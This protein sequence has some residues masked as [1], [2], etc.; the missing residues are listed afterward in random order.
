MVDYVK[1]MLT[2]R[3]QCPHFHLDV[4][5]KLGTKVFF[6]HVNN[7]ILMY[8]IDADESTMIVFFNP[9][10]HTFHYHFQQ[11]V[12]RVFSADGSLEQIEG[13]MDIEVSPISCSVYLVKP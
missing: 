6:E 4:E 10:Y 2:L 11:G 9:T 8:E 7:Q 1:N 5:D 3:R 13:L 12:T